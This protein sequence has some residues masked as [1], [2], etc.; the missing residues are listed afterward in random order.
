VSTPHGSFRVRVLSNMKVGMRIG[1][2]AMLPQKQ[3]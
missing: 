2:S 1:M 3:N